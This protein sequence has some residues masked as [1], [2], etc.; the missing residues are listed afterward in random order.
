[1]TTTTDSEE[2]SKDES[3]LYFGMWKSVWR[4]EGARVTAKDKKYPW[5]RRIRDERVPFARVERREGENVFREMSIALISYIKTE[6]AFQ[7]GKKTQD[8]AK[9]AFKDAS[10]AIMPLVMFVM[11]PKPLWK[12]DSSI[13]DILLQLFESLVVLVADSARKMF[14]AKP[15]IVY[16]E[17]MYEFSNTAKDIGKLF[18]VI[19][20][21]CAKI[22]VPTRIVKKRD[23]TQ[24]ME[25]LFLNFAR[26]IQ[27]LIKSLF[28]YGYVGNATSEATMRC[29]GTAST[30]GRTLDD[31]GIGGLI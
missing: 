16:E 10:N 5:M 17:P 12:I 6:F 20:P 2:F 23:T 28:N 25:E 27:H 18:G 13:D 14:S 7:K 29:I 26:S 30:I 21:F 9:I 22:L 24:H 11:T 8:D 1:M 15:A 19:A 31:Y 3:Q 4:K